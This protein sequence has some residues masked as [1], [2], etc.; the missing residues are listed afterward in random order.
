MTTAP[1]SLIDVLVSD[2][3]AI[4]TF[5]N[6]P[7]NALSTRLFDELE[8][9]V[10]RLESETAVRAVIFAATGSAAFLS[11]ADINEL[12]ARVADP[13]ALDA[14][15]RRV[16]AVFDRVAVLPQPTIAA[17]GANAVGGGLEFVLLTDL[18][19]AGNDV[20]FGLPEVRLGLIPGA[21]GTQRLSRR[22]PSRVAAEMVLTGRTITASR[23]LELGLVNRVVP[24]E[25]VVDE[26]ADLARSLATMPRTAVQAAKAALIQG[27]AS[28]LAP[29][30]A[31]ESTAFAVAAASND[32]QEGCSAF[33]ERR[34]P[35]FTHT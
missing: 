22:I 33:L 32:A 5:D 1:L 30:L 15:T 8:A 19:V 14:H 25:D 35:G 21:G 20:K 18:V 9:V 2:H 26:A 24:T 6:P 31:A 34:K 13:E 28:I 4:V 27:E 11:G 10:E 29:G 7:A 23:A 17:V 16:R 3:V 12:P